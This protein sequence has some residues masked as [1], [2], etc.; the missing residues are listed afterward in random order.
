MCHDCLN[1]GCV[2]NGD[3]DH[4]HEVVKDVGKQNEGSLTSL[5]Y[6]RL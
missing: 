2:V 5:L 1:N 4:R 6:R 3:G